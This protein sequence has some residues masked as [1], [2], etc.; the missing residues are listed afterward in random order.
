MSLLAI[1]LISCKPNKEDLK[2]NISELEAKLEASIKT[3]ID[4][5]AANTLLESYDDYIVYFQEDSLAEEYLYRAGE[6][7][8]NMK[9]T[10]TAEKYLELY[11]NNYDSGPHSVEVLFHLANLNENQKAD[12]VTAEKYYNLVISKFP[13]SN[14]AKISSQALTTLGKTPDEILEML[15]AKANKAETDS[16]IVETVIP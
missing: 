9:K 16:A 4:I 14:F 8:L 3:N 1:S 7:A 10:I 11:E 13:E 12:I 6:L 15:K 2:A 5:Q